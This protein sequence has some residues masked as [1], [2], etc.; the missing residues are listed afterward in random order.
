MSFLNEFL[1]QDRS[2]LTSIEEN[3]DEEGESCKEISIERDSQEHSETITSFQNDDTKDYESQS[4]FKNKTMS[5]HKKKQISNNTTQ[6]SAST[7][8][9]K[10]LV[11]KKGQAS[12]PIDDFF[13]LMATTVKNF[14]PIDQH[15]VKSKVFAIVNDIESKYLMQS[16]QYLTSSPQQALAHFTSS[17]QQSP[18]NFTP[19]SQQCPTL[20]TPSPQQSP[21]N[22]TSSPQQSLTHFTSSPQSSSTQ[23][24]AYE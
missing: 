4:N 17:S 13:S 22:Y 19:S 8:L 6:E 3:S 21:A 14:S 15:Y 23:H 11:D 7:T 16:P 5:I 10:Y 12:H 9:M 24:N 20:F 1:N 2:R 18:A